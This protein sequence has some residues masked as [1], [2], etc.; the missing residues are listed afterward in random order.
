[1]IGCTLA[2]VGFFLWAGQVTKLDFASQ[3]WFIILGG[4]GTGFMLGPASTDAVNRASR[5]SYGEATGITQTVRNYAASLGIAILGT[6]LVSEMRW[7]V[8]TSLLAVDVPSAQ[9]A[10]RSIGHLGVPR[11]GQERQY[12]S[13]LHPARLCVRHADGY[14]RHGGDHGRGGCRGDRRAQAG[15]AG[16]AERGQCE[17]GGGSVSLKRSSP[18][19]IA[20]PDATSLDHH[21]R[22]HRDGPPSDAR[23]DPSDKRKTREQK[24]V[25]EKHEPPL[26]GGGT[27]AAGQ[28]QAVTARPSE[29][30]M[31]RV[32]FSTPDATPAGLAGTEPIIVAL[33]GG[34]N[35]PDADPDHSQQHQEKPSL[36]TECRQGDESTATPAIPPT[37]RERAL[38][39]GNPT[40]NG[41]V[42]PRATGMTIKLSPERP[43]PSRFPARAEGHEEQDAEHYQVGKQTARDPGPQACVGTAEV[44]HRFLGDRRGRGTRRQGSTHRQE[45]RGSMASS[46]RG[47]CRRRSL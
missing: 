41:A 33:F 2:A 20:A 31:P 40:A 9:A 10:R 13:P 18:L 24:E 3:Q 29:V 1:M 4:A 17:P 19:G 46:S 43:E 42:R 14:L 7:R 39:I 6:I 45:A 36:R 37:A 22:R 27:A 23:H 8:L 30:P 34:V 11:R 35:A 26:P 21:L 12:H 5:L 47:R 44:E 32:M 28:R 38:C 15:P 16:G 25:T